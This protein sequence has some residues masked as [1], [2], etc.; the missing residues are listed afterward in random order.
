MKKI[1]LNHGSFALVDD[2]DYETLSKYTWSLNRN[3]YAI[4]TI[5]GITTSMHRLIMNP[6]DNMVVDH[7]DGHRTD[8]QKSNLR[9]CTNSENMQNQMKH[10]RNATSQYKGVYFYKDSQKWVSRI[11]YNNHHFGIGSYDT[12]MDAAIA[13]NIVN[14][15]LRPVSKNNEFFVPI[16]EK[17]LTRYIAKKVIK[18]CNVNNIDE[19]M[20]KYCKI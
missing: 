8:N 5:K 17:I 19:F 10:N 2:E 6:P 13:Y 7:I 20:G 1:S 14:Y 4:S 12:E 9:I 15:L 16:N 3:N 11:R 18:F